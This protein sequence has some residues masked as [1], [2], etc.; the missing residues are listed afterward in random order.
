MPNY[1]YF[2]GDAPARKKIELIHSGLPLSYLNYPSI[3][4]SRGGWELTI[5]EVKGYLQDD[6]RWTY[7][8]QINERKFDG[9]APTQKQVDAQREHLIATYLDP[10][11]I[12]GPL[13]NWVKGLVG[14]RIAEIEDTDPANSSKR[15]RTLIKRAREL[16]AI[17]RAEGISIAVIPVND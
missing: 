15:K 12:E 17:A 11:N 4:R 9:R 6:S 14:Y 7:T 1:P 3:V 13:T 10:D 16:E 2:K 8:E 5:D